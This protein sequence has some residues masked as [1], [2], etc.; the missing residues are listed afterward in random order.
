MGFH[1]EL[2]SR[3]LEQN[4]EFLKEMYTADLEGVVRWFDKLDCSVSFARQA[5]KGMKIEQYLE[6]PALSHV[7]LQVQHYSSDIRYG[8]TAFD[9]ST[10]KRVQH[11]VWVECPYSER[12]FGTVSRLFKEAYGEAL[13]QV[14]TL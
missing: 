4:M 2:T 13:E 10:P 9:M 3:K 5:D 7:V 11:F 8:I 6:F 1:L 12:N 14:Q